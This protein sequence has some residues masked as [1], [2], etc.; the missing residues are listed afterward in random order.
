MKRQKGPWQINSS[1]STAKGG[2]KTIQESGFKHKPFV[3]KKT[4]R[5]WLHQ[6][7]LTKIF[8]I[9]SNDVN[10]AHLS[11]IP[12]TFTE[13]VYSNS[14]TEF[15][16]S[17]VVEFY[18]TFDVLPDMLNELPSLKVACNIDNRYI[19]AM[20]GVE[21]VHGSQDLTWKGKLLFLKWSYYN[22]ITPGSTYF[23]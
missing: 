21:W 18:M 17:A 6:L 1:W 15:T 20:C 23:L 14:V 3:C 7:Q 10:S 16:D 11:S 22:K 5:W 19:S 13:T 12:N 8:L 2:S 9:R 4:C